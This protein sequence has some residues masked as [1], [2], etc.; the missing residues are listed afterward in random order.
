M[1]YNYSFYL[2]AL[3]VLLGRIFFLFLLIF[4]QKIRQEMEVLFPEILS[5]KH[6]FELTLKVSIGLQIKL[7]PFL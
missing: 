4:D 2:L 6:N 7:Y 5:F 1:G 3:L